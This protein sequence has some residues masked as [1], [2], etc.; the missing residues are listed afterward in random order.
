MM[1][2]PDGE[3]SL[4]IYLGVLIQYQC[5]TDI[6]TDGQTSCNSIVCAMQAL[7]GKNLHE[8]SP[9]TC[10]P[11]YQAVMA[12]TIGRLQESWRIVRQ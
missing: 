11:T 10:N 5:V 3:K 4:M 7:R 8:Y 1:W 6:Q 2:L 12:K 9:I